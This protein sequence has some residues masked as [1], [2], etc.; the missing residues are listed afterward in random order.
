L[1]GD[2]LVTFRIR[3]LNGVGLRSP[4]QTV[5]PRGYGF[6]PGGRTGGNIREWLI[7]N[8]TAGDLGIHDIQL[9]PL[10]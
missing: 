3:D 7:N 2:T 9:N 1:S 8:G 10:R 6:V 5:P 4:I